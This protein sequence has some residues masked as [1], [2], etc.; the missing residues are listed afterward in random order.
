[1]PRPIPLHDEAAVQRDQ[2]RRGT[3]PSEFFLEQMQ[4]GRIEACANRISHR[5]GD[6]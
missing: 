3:S 4:L 6:L 2:Q 5:P 1:M